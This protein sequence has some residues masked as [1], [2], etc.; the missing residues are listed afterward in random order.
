MRVRAWFAF[1]LAGAGVLAVLPACGGGGSSGAGGGPPL[2]P[3]PPPSNLP[4]HVVV[5]VQENRT[6]DNLFHTLPGVD[7]V[8]L[9]V[10]RAE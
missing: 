10:G 5:V 4:A 3:T 6:V 9:G 2:H 8:A 7:T 1:A